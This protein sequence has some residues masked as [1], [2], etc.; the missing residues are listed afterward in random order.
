M[1]DPRQHRP[2]TALTALALVGQ[3]GLAV[4]LPVAGGA[5]LGAWLDARW[6]LGGLATALLILAGLTAGLAAAIRMLLK[7]ARWKP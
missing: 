4:A 1:P 7:E 2:V 5:F 3:V 6:N